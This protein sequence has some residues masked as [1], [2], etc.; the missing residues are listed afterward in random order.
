MSY[1]NT[2]QAVDTEKALSLLGIEFK[3]Q[4]GY[5]KFNCPKP[6]CDGQAAIKAY[7]DKKNLYYCPKCKSS[8]HIIGLAMNQKSLK[9]EDA[10][11]VLIKN[12]LGVNAKKITEELNL[13]YELVYHDFLK[14]KGLSEDICY[15]QEIGVPKGKA[16]LSG[17]VAFVIRDETAMKIAYYGIRMKDGNPVFHKTFNPELYLYN[18]CNVGFEGDVYFT[19]NIFECLKMIDDKKQAICNFGLPYLSPN[20][21]ALL[22]SLHKVVFKVDELLVKTFAIQLAQSYRGFFRFEH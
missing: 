6:D 9:W 1:K 21:L 16:M 10:N 12:A 8:G 14:N 17:C 18:F 7:G 4:G 20:H 19:T 13:N 3:T 15:Q 5:A 22:E 11:E 2:L